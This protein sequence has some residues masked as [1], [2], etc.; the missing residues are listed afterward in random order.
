MHRV[1]PSQADGATSWLPCGPRT[2]LYSVISAAVLFRQALRTVK[3]RQACW[4]HIA[5]DAMPPT[6]IQL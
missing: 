3:P 6:H 2:W 5:C 4:I 1:R